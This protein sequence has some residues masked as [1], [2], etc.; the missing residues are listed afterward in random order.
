MSE[1][2][3]K[4]LARAGFGSRRSLET[5]IVAGEVLVN[6]TVA[7][8]GLRVSEKDEIVIQGQRV[9]QKSA[10]DSACRVLLYHKPDGE[11][12]TR[13]DPEKRPTVFDNL[14]RL[15][16]GRW[17]AVGRLDFNTAGLLLFTTDGDLA[18][19]L[20]HPRNQIEREYAVRVFGEVDAQILNQLRRGVKLTDGMAAFTEIKDGGG[21]GRNHWYH[22]TL[23]EGRNREVRRMWESQDV[24]V[25]RLIRIR[26]GD[27]ALPRDLRKGKF[28]ELE[29]Q[30]ILA[31]GHSLGLTLKPYQRERRADNPFKKSQGLSR[32]K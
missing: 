18:E 29:P 12:C 7:T 28:R 22:V 13:S 25:S 4:V 9:T 2:L 14:P 31:L 23:K 17:I 32:R 26:F 3:Q 11:V 1:K 24:T 15:Q 5:L 10:E 8:L 30:H 19:A 27:I 6:G 20:M 16:R 21:E